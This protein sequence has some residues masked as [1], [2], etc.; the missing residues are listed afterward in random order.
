MYMRTAF[1]RKRYQYTRYIRMYI[2]YVPSHV[3]YT[4]LS[5]CVN[6]CTPTGLGYYCSIT[7]YDIRTR[8][9]I[10]L[11]ISSRCLWSARFLRIEYS[12]GMLGSFFP[13]VFRVFCVP[14]H[15]TRII[16]EYAKGAS[17]RSHQNTVLWSSYSL[18]TNIGNDAPST[19]SSR[20]FTG[21]PGGHLRVQPSIPSLY[22]QVRGCAL[23]RI[24]DECRLIVWI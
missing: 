14:D 2:I 4:K 20:R 3:W 8:Y 19:H 22:R 1:A 6:W 11:N 7:Y 9:G 21:T 17:C 10:C 13:T 18:P 12:A 15:A 23:E 5:V 24:L 16:F